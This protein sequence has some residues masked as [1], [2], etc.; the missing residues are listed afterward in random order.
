M[1]LEK[2]EQLIAVRHNSPMVLGIG[3]HANYIASDPIALLNYTNNFIYLEQNDI[4]II[5]TDSYQITNK[6]PSSNQR[7]TSA[8]TNLHHPQQSRV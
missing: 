4:A 3:E 2:P 5:T 7:H 8:T 6:Y 1:N